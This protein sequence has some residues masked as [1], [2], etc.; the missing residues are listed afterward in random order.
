[1][2]T[3]DEA[4]DTIE[5]KKT[6]PETLEAQTE[7]SGPVSAPRFIENPLPLPKKHEKRE[8]DYQYEVAEDKMNYDREIKEN[9]D[10]DIS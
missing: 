5:M 4:K 6:E 9:D 7:A 1:M 8:M 3:M 2:Q 10:F